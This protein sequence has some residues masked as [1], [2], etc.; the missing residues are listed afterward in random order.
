MLDKSPFC[1]GNSV[2]ATSGINGAGTNTQ[3]KAK[4]ADNAEVFYKD[5]I[6]SAA[7]PDKSKAAPYELGRTLAYQSG[8]AV[9]WL[10]QKFN[11]DL[12]L[13]GRLGVQEW[14]YC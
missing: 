4:V 2:K 8:P 5:I 10:Q 3:F 6:M 14:L 7:G 12:S 11:L 13:L 1:G 9:E